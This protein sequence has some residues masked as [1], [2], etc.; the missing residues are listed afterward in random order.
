M[1]AE[2]LSMKREHKG[3]YRFYVHY[4]GANRRLDEWVREQQLD[5]STVLIPQKVKKSAA[6]QSDIS[7]SDSIPHDVSR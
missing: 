3:G 2:I 4:V 6:Q 5:L 7:S 1:E